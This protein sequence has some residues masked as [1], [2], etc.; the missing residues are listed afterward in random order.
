MVI[1]VVA[2][3]DVGWA[4]IAWAGQMML[5][6]LTV[7]WANGNSCHRL[8]S[9]C[10]VR[11][12]HPL[13]HSSLFTQAFA[14]ADDVCQRSCDAKYVQRCLVRAV[15]DRNHTNRTHWQYTAKCSGCSSFLGGASSSSR[16]TLTGSGSNQLAF[17][18]ASAKP[19]NPSSNTSTIPVHDVYGYW[20]HDFSVAGNAAFASLVSKDS[21]KK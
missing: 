12:A 20:S 6:P 1:Q 8:L 11:L 16:T 3:V 2:P 13:T 18:Y 17:A 21:W 14:K 10:H 5:C 19:S 4:G 15:Q 9:L 7:V